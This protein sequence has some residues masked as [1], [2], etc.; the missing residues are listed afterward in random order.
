MQ[1]LIVY[2]SASN[3][4]C[5]TSRLAFCREGKCACVYFRGNS[6][7]MSS[8]PGNIGCKLNDR[9]TG[10]LAVGNHRIAVTDHVIRFNPPHCLSIPSSQTR[11]VTLTPPSLY[12]TVV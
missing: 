10:R 6:N 8:G 7:R 3:N 9:R 2:S 11:T 1:S 12:T 5:A 4:Y